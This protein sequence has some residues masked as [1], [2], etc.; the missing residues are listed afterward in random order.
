MRE[1]ICVHPRVGLCCVVC[2]KGICVNAFETSQ[3][4]ILSFQHWLQLVH[5]SSIGTAQE[6]HPALIFLYTRCILLM[7]T[8]QGLV[9]SSQP[10][11]PTYRKHEKWK[12]WAYE[13][14]VWEIEHWSFTPLIMSS[15]GGIGSATNVCYKRLA[16][17]LS[18]EWN[19]PYT[20]NM[21][22]M[23][24]FICSA[25]ILNTVH[26]S[27]LMVIYSSKAS[28]PPHCVL[29]QGSPVS[30]LWTLCEASVHWITHYFETVLLLLSL[31]NSVV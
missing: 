26:Q 16:S 27:Y 11:A 17:L 22:S 7:R 28:L 15:T 2:W 23:Y 1:Y 9:D 3:L 10:L 5:S 31:K 19:L 4:L 18:A 13:Q 24:T 8:C 14:R 6:C 21:D 25:Q 20:S 29:W 12:I 30:N